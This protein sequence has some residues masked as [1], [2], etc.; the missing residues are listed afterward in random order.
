MTID[1][2]NNSYS[3]S[4]PHIMLSFKLKKDCEVV[5]LVNE[6]KSVKNMKLLNKDNRV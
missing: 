4:D 6:G 2:L 5:Q 3:S 1:H